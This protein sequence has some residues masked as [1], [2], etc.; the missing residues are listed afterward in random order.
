[1]TRAHINKAPPVAREVD[2]AAHVDRVLA[3]AAADPPVLGIARGASGVRR[4]PAV[5][6][7]IC[8]EKGART[9]APV[10]AGPTVA[11][12]GPSPFAIMRLDVLASIGNG[13]RTLALLDIAEPAVWPD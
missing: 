4:S 5:C 6:S 3:N 2:L 11:P 9:P 10:C 12:H 8:Q 1:M 7:S 13:L